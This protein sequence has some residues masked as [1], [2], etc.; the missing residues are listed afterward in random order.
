MA[1]HTGLLYGVEMG[2]SA[3]SLST[4]NFSQKYTQ[5][6]YAKFLGI[7]EKNFCVWYH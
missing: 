1:T 6:F 4:W 2:F 3:K 7:E 5:T